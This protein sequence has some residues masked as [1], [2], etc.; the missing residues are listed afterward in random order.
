MGLL[1]RL[2]GTKPEDM[3]L[4]SLLTA[5]I[6]LLDDIYTTLQRNQARGK[7]EEIESAIRNIF[8]LGRELR[9]LL[10]QASSAT[11][12]KKQKD[13]IRAIVASLNLIADTATEN[14]ALN[15]LGLPENIKL[16]LRT[17][18]AT[19][20]NFLTVLLSRFGN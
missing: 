9:T 11:P 3:D 8:H 7:H 14:N 2:F 1:K 20:Q 18:Q 17:K 6:E 15:E 16:T 13:N 19:L 4:P 10:A 12:A 5:I